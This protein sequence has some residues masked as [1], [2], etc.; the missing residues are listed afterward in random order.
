[1][2]PTL[3]GWG[4]CS[5]SLRAEICTHYL[6]FFCTGDLSVVPHLLIYA[7]I[8]S[9]WTPRSLLCTLGIIQDTLLCRS[10]CF[11]FGHWVLSQGLPCL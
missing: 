1:M 7:L 10:A 5:P 6:E 4:S 11:V 8:R 9:G 2:P 3:P